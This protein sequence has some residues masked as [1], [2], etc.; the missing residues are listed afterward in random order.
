MFGIVNHGTVA[1]QVADVVGGDAD[2]VERH[3]RPFHQ[4]PVGGF[5]EADAGAPLLE[6][7][8]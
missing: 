8:A 5:E 1:T 3:R 6:F 7:G 4:I 2:L